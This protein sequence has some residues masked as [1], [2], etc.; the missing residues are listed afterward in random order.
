MTFPVPR[1]HVSVGG[2]R[3]SALLDSGNRRKLERFG[4]LVVERSETG[5]IR[6]A[7]PLTSV[8]GSQ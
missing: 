2:S 7:T 1:I 4:P 3:D 8:T 6:I 5:G